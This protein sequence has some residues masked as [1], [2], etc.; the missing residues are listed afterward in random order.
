MIQV[1]VKAKNFRLTI[2][3]PYAILYTVVS[4]LSSKLLQKGI[5]KWTKDHF[6]KKKIDFTCPA[7]DKKLLKSIVKEMK[8]YKGCTLVDLKANDGTEVKVQL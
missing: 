7:I 3:V 4:I 1:K 2:P 6:E 8:N 5:N